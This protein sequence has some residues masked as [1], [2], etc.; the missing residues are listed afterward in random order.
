MQDFR[1]L[2]Q[3]LG[4]DRAKTYIQSGNVVFDYD[5]PASDLPDRISDK[6]R[7]NFGFAPQVLILRRDEMASVMAANPFIEEMQDARHV[8][9]W[10]TTESAVDPDFSKLASLA[11]RDEQFL[12]QGKTFFL[13]APNGIGRSKLAAQVE[14]VLGVGATARNWRTMLKVAELLAALD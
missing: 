12:L 14:K 9:V 3:Q 6:I 8:H 4:C 11:G 10:L 2:L 7:A 13:H 1:A 5:A